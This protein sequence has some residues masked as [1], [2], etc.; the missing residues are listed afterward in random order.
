MKYLRTIINWKIQNIVKKFQNLVT[1][2]EN[3]YY[4][5]NKRKKIIN[6]DYSKSCSYQAHILNYPILIATQNLGMHTIH[7][8][9]VICV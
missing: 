7:Q 9:I 6:M 2:K 1:T 8:I 5:A 4:K 3:C